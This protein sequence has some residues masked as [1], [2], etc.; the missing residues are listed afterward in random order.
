MTDKEGSARTTLQLSL[1]QDEKKALKQMALDNGTTVAG[2][3]R[4]WLKE[5]QSE[6]QK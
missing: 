5:K 4:S 2:L 1:T 3:I 6:V